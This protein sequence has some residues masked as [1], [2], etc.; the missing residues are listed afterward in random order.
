MKQLAA[1]LAAVLVL[2]GI[3]IAA[4]QNPQQAA[5]GQ[6]Q[7][8]P[9]ATFKSAVDLVAV[10][11]NII[12]KTGRPV[13]GLEAAD[14]TLLVDGKPRTVASAEYIPA[15]RD[16][17]PS[18]ERPTY[19]ST[20]AASAGGRLIMIVGDQGNIGAG[21]GKLVMDGVARFLSTLSPADR[22][23]LVAIPG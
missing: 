16:V 19:Y 8:Q 21:R 23:G 22:V 5:A 20:N 18:S 17:D 13:S 9:A 1:S 3:T 10:D 11:V 6:D 7:Q 2:T 12:D 4:Q 14:F 15:V